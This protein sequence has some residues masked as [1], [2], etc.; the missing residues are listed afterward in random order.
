M[1]FNKEDKHLINNSRQEEGY[2]SRRFLQYFQTLYVSNDD[3]CNGHALAL[4]VLAVTA[5]L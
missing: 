2:N 1:P 3:E 5:V 4:A